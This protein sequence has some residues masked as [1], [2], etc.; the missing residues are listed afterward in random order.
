MV[1]N[2]FSVL[3]R[4]S[5]SWLDCVCVW[6]RKNDVTT[7]YQSGQS[8]SRQLNMDWYISNDFQQIVEH[9]K[10]ERKSAVFSR[11][12]CMSFFPYNAKQTPSVSNRSQTNTKLAKCSWYCVNAVCNNVV[13]H[14]HT[15]NGNSSNSSRAHRE[16]IHTQPQSHTV[17]FSWLPRASTLFA[18][19]LAHNK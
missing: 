19:L 7:R 9:A 3:S 15:T 6:I 16:T 4:S 18:R 5:D 12:C 2:L 17:Q 11:F 14:A 13:V 8:V 10:S 1:S